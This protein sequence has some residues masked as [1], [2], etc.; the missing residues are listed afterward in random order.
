MD[1]VHWHEKNIYEETNKVEP[2]ASGMR[3]SNIYPT[4]PQ[5]GH[6]HVVA[7]SSKLI[8]NCWVVGE[9]IEN[10]FTV[11]VNHNQDVSDLR[12][13]V[14]KERKHSVLQNIDASDLMLWKVRVTIVTMPTLPT[15]TGFRTERP[16]A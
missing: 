11:T 10:G 3:L 12:K 15:C 16:L 7:W 13:Q 9:D 14:I 6:V 1:S 4:P 5:E 2:L 8:L